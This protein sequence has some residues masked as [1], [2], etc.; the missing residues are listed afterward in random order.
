MLIVPKEKEAYLDVGVIKNYD[1]KVSINRCANLSVDEANNLEMLK[2]RFVELWLNFR[3]DQEMQQWSNEGN[4]VE[5]ENEILDAFEPNPS[6]ESLYI[7]N[8]MGTTISVRWMM[9]SCELKELQLVNCHNC[10]ILPP[11]GKLRSLV[12]LDISGMNRLKTVG[13]DFLGITETNEEDGEINMAFVSFP[14][15]R[16]LCFERMLQWEEWEGEAI[17]T[18]TS[19]VIMPCT[20]SRRR[21]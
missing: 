8:Y 19:L 4:G 10:E 11:L 17:A 6:F 13:L 18:K 20:S 5:N 1:E 7:W 9:L 3:D 14:K 15:L 2:H 16:R 12:S 21:S